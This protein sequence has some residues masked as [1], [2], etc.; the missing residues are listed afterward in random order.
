MASLAIFTNGN[1]D[2]LRGLNSEATDLVY[3]DPPFNSDHRIPIRGAA[4]R[5]AF[6]T[7]G[8]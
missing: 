1:P 4:A 5:A 8:H 2:V 6:W 3:L 7:L